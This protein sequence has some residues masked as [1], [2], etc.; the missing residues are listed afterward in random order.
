MPSPQ[1]P[2]FSA[3][4]IKFNGLTNRIVTELWLTPAFDPKEY[5]ESPFP[6]YKTTALWDTGATSS[7]VTQTTAKSI[8]LIP[9]GNTMVN[10]AGGTS[11]TNTYVT[12]FFLPNRV[13]VYGVFVSEC[14]DNAGNFGAIIGMD[15]IVK[16]DFAITNFNGFTWMTYRFPSMQP[17]DYVQEANRIQFGGVGRNDPCPCGKKDRVAI[18][19]SSSIVMGNRHSRSLISSHVCGNGDR[20]LRSARFLFGRAQT[21]NDKC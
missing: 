10:H 3:F 14:S 8:G 18:Q 5:P 19:S 1:R 17:I 16:G 6:L 2:V 9:T 21:Y 20:A 13:T 12:N 7:V 11:Q 4:T 15:I